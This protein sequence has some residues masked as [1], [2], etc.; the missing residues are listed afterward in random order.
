MLFARNLSTALFSI[1]IIFV[2][3][4]S[5]YSCPYPWSD[6]YEVSEALVN[7]IPIP[8]GYRRVRTTAETFEDWL[9][10]LPL[11][12]GKP[13][14]H[15][16]DGREKLN[17]KAHFAVV[18]IDVGGKNLQQCADAVIRLRAEYLYSLD[19]Y[20]KIHFNFTSGDRA[21]FAKWA[22]GYRPIVE[23]NKV[24]WTRSETEDSSYHSFKKYLERV[25]MYAGSY[26]L[27]KELH[28]VQDIDEMRIGDVFIEGGFPG[29]AVIVV[30]IA[31]DKE[32]GKKLFLLAQSYMPAQEVHILNNPANASLN[33]W[34]GLDFGEILHT[35]EWTF[36]KSDLMRF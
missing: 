3:T 19:S 32:T 1:A 10:N 13:A 2:L 25:F 30:D 34:Y 23:G 8:D 6:G 17:Q 28:S 24:R 33:P 29:H 35:P 9:R 7:R 20:E 16:Y 27:S 4:A 36:N 15:L 22:D 14:V 18:D 21:D 5:T 11:K 26:S 12:K 31:F